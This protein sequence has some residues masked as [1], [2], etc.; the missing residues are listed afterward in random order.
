M[1]HLQ[2]CP[3]EINAKHVDEPRTGRFFIGFVTARDLEVFDSGS[4]EF[5]F[6]RGGVWRL[7]RA[8]DRRVKRYERQESDQK[9]TSKNVITRA[10]EE[11][12]VYRP[13]DNSRFSLER[14]MTV[15]ARL[16]R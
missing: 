4:D 13:H 10:P 14:A 8:W 2:A 5:G 16:K 9:A 15:I 12:N 11:R 1:N 7:L 6:L 3:A